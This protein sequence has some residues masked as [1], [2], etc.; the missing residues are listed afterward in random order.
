MDDTE[1]RIT[2][3][4]RIYNN[5]DC[6]QI[7]DL[8]YGLVLIDHLLINTEEMLDTSVHFTFDI[9]ILHMCRYF[10]NDLI[11]KFFTFCFSC[12]DLIHQIKKDFRL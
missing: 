11:Y 7:V 8:I 10:L 4:H 6:K 1:R 12:I 9:G 2:V 5:T 3:L